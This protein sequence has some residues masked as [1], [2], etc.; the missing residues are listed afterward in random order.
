MSGTVVTKIGAEVSAIENLRKGVGDLIE[1]ETTLLNLQEER[2]RRSQANLINKEFDNIKKHG[3]PAIS[4]LASVWATLT[5]TGNAFLAPLQLAKAGI[6]EIVGFKGVWSDFWS[7]AYG[8][9]AQKARIKIDELTVRVAVLKDLIEKSVLPTY[10]EYYQNILA[11]YEAEL[12]FQKEVHRNHVEKVNDLRKERSER[13]NIT[14]QIESQTAAENRLKEVREATEIIMQKFSKQIYGENIVTTR[15]AIATKAFRSLSTVGVASL[16]DLQAQMKEVE[17]NE[18]LKLFSHQIKNLGEEIN[19]ADSE[20]ALKRVYNAANQLGTRGT[21]RLEDY[22]KEIGSLLQ[23]QRDLAR[24]IKEETELE[25]LA[26]QFSRISAV[27]TQTTSNFDKLI[28]SS[29]SYRDSVDSAID[30]IDKERSSLYS[31]QGV[32]AA[33]G[34]GTKEW[35]SAMEDVII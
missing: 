18:F 6:K 7:A 15:I 3:I 4:G 10:K 16:E 22:N 2:V 5:E 8:A 28:S 1:A 34:R 26:V 24:V 29:S 17:R 9:E 14:K 31:L 13:A 23:G 35:K 11:G 12:G 30:S 27:V 25:L 20:Q 19:A 32:V 21:K 33:T